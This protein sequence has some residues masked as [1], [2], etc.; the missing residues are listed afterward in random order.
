[1]G[2]FDFGVG[3][4]FYLSIFST[5]LCIVYGLLHWNKEDDNGTV[6]FFKKWLKE[7]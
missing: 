3:L 2:E 6:K 7:R 4:A 5:F 1:M